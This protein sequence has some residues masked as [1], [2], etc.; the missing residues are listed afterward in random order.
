MF[1]RF[2]GFIREGSLFGRG[3]RL[4]LGVSGGVDSMVMLHLMANNGYD[5]VAAHC[6]FLLRGAESDEDQDF[7]AR[8]CKKIDIPVYTC[9][10]NTK[11]YAMEKGISLQ[12]AARELRYNWFYS[13]LAELGCSLIAIAH[14]K[15]DITETFLI[16]LLRGTGLRG[17][18][19]IKARSGKIVRP[20]LFAGRP[21]ILEYATLNKIPFREDS[22]NMDIKYKRNRI[23]HIIIPE[24]EK[25]SPGFVGTIYE[26]AERLKETDEIVS[27][28]LEQ[29]FNNLFSRENGE[30][31]VK[32]SSLLE[33]DPLP[34][35]LYE[36][37]RRW[38]FSRETTDNIVSALQGPPGKL[39]YSNTHR[40]IRDREYLIITPIQQ[41]QITRY[42][43]DEDST[44]LNEPLNLRISKH[45]YHKGFSIPSEPSIACL[46]LDMLHFPLILRK[47][48]NGDYFQP[49]GMGGLKKLSDFFIDNKFSIADKER[50]WIL[51]SG[52]RIVWITGHRIDDRFKITDR[53]KEVLMIEIVE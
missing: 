20:L 6:N 1:E 5:I 51:A 24:L 33:L 47:W 15:N 28:A 3:D 18:T 26:T 48:Q 13:L 46:D 37:L 2:T 12:M 4:L 42:Y 22:S 40:L 32:V 39:F 16:N 49:L 29:R 8:E 35:Y 50:T 9:S 45:I 43:I 34:A 53:T 11:E 30:Y 27:E 31:K 19:G 25:I 41:V 44:R 14:N 23:R 36:F 21:E 10:F 38:G 7:V 52:N 17:L